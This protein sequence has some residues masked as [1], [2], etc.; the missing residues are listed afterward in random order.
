MKAIPMTEVLAWLKEHHPALHHTAEQDRDWLWLTADLRGDQNK[1]VR[2]SIN[3]EGGFRFAKRGHT[4]P[5]GRVAF[6]GHSCSHPI[7]FKR[8]GGGS[9]SGEPKGKARGSSS[10]KRPDPLAAAPQEDERLE[11]L[12]AAFV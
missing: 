11:D 7:G 3:H 5:S 1:A 10:A 12:A 8:K 9:P 2:D 4:L 6:W